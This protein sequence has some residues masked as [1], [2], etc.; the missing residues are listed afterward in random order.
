MVL[1]VNV[2]DIIHQR[3]VESTRIEYKAS[4]NPEPI[5]HS[6]TAFAND[7]DNLG[8]GYIFVGIEEEDGLPKFPVA[9]LAKK[10]LDAIQKDLFAK[11][12][13]IEPR[14]IP[15]VEPCV[16]D[17]RNILAIWVPGGD[18]RPYKC[19]QKIYMNKA[20]EKSGKAY[21]IRKMSNTIRANAAEEKELIGLA[22][23]IPF[24]DRVN[25]HAGVNDMRSSL[26]SEYLHAVGSELYESSLTRSLDAVAT[27]MKL[28]KGPK[29][30]R[31]P[32]NVGLM[33]F[34]ERPDDFFPY[35]RIEV[36]DKPD[37]TGVG[38]KERI[39]TGPLNKQLQDALAYIQNYVIAEYVTKIP[40]QAEALRVYN[41][42]YEA[43]EEALTNA[44]YHR[45][46]QIHEP[47]TV[48]VTPDKLEILSFPGPDRS[49]TD[50]DIKNNVMVA[51][52]YRNR[53]I[54]DFLKEL[55]MAEGRNTGIPLILKAMRQ[56]GSDVPVFKTDEERS[57]LR[58]IF[59]V[60]QLFLKNAAI[61]E[62]SARVQKQP[63]R[64][65]KN[66]IRNLVIETLSSKGALSMG[67]IALE[68]GYKKLTDTLRSVVNEMLE[69][70]E[71]HY[72]YPDKPN[73]RNQKI[74]LE[75]HDF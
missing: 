15:I 22:R 74:I 24:D 19:P 26:I 12:N 32:V 4:W 7:F 14:Y 61:T 69:S 35:S 40:G 58:V 59:P 55:K 64:K 67:E 17:G 49:I 52:R 5:I 48:T 20:H 72:L 37:P 28:L 31:K 71:A 39:F 56:N 21:Y 38:M 27:D 57:Y 18:E 45:S 54:G 16:V 73:S 46:Y 42:P 70:G 50:E 34:N 53:R 51:N 29:E 63:V 6:I 43:I 8:G 23:N 1:P 44:V 36:V 41:W 3:V 65:S 60:H 47:I 10:S 25:Y 62:I 11:C 33:F 9:G 66:E 30:L 68:L 2:E 75:N 13:P